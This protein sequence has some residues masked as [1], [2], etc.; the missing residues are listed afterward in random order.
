[1]WIQW[2]CIF[3]VLHLP[4]LFLQNGLGN[5]CTTFASWRQV[6]SCLR[7][8]LWCWEAKPYCGPCLQFLVFLVALNQL[9]TIWTYWDLAP[10]GGK[11]EQWKVV[12]GSYFSSS[13]PKLDFSKMQLL[14]NASLKRSGGTE[15]SA[16]SR[17]LHM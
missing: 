2:Y 14:Y 5:T 6:S 8:C 10:Y 9:H 1:M 13:S 15:P 4:L 17:A 11:A 12:A 3:W 16:S 7:C